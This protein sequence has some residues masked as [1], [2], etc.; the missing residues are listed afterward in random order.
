MFNSVKD[1]DNS[2]LEKKMFLIWL[3]TK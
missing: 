2:N 1:V 3:G